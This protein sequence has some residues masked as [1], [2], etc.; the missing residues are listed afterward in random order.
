M[1]IK[2][3][4]TFQLTGEE[5]AV[6]LRAFKKFGGETDIEKRIVKRAIMKI[7]GKRTNRYPVHPDVTCTI[8]ERQ[9]A[10]K[11]YRRHYFTCKAKQRDKGYKVDPEILE[12]LKY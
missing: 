1:N 6:L 9:F 3:N 11:I 7:L 8:C 10:H 5:R 12:R 2:G 4:I